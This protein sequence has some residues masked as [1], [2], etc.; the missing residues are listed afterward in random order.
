[1]ETLAFPLPHE[2][3]VFVGA[4]AGRGIRRHAT[5]PVR[6]SIAHAGREFLVDGPASAQ[7]AR[8]QRNGKDDDKMTVI[9]RHLETSEPYMVDLRRA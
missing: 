9:D 7:P 2:L 4:G 3:I 8:Q 1:L 5:G 6:D